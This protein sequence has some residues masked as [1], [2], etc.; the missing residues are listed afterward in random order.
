MNCN[1]NITIHYAKHIT[2]PYFQ[3]MKTKNIKQWVDLNATAKEIYDTLMDSKK[4]S[5]LIGAK[6]QIE[7]KEGGEFK[8]WGGD[9]VGKNV[10]LVP[11]EKIVQLWRF[12]YDDW[13]EDYFSKV[14]FKFKKNKKGGTRILFWQSGIPEN[15]V[16]ELEEGWKDY[17]WEPLKKFF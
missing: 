7:N 16:S 12:K 3:F 14:T 6:A 2:I 8:I 10:E 1:V 11:G 17:Y 4:H 9:I 15:H 13:A 5:K